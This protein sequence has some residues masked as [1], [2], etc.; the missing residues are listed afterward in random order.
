MKFLV[1]FHIFL[2]LFLRV[3]VSVIQENDKSACELFLG[4]IHL[5][6]DEGL[7]MMVNLWLLFMNIHDRKMS[8]NAITWP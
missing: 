4:S 7:S 8:M 2:P 5:Y 6:C 3:Q 1:S